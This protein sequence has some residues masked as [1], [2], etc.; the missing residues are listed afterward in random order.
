MVARHQIAAT[1][2]FGQRIQCFRAWTKGL[3]YTR[4]PRL[5]TV[6]EIYKIIFGFLV[7]PPY[8]FLLCA[9]FRRGAGPARAFYARVGR[10]LHV[11]NRTFLSRRYQE[12]FDVI[13]DVE[14]RQ[15]TEGS[16]QNR[17]D[18]VVTKAR[19][20]RMCSVSVQTTITRRL[21]RKL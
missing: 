11:G 15:I 2:L 12:S 20:S 21:K 9:F 14:M 6:R 8:H 10:T 19:N 16:S 17:K 13:V 3:V 5:K 1:F 4:G 7:V 18:Q